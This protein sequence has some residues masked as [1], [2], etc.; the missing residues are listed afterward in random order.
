MALWHDV[1]YRLRALVGR[2]RLDHD[3]DEELQF[4]LEQETAARVAAGMSPQE[5]RRTAMRDFGGMERV[6]E[7]GREARGVAPLED[8][9]RDLRY[10][11]RSLSRAP[12]FSIVVI[13]TLALG[14]GA[15][16]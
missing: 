12:G 16:T 13:A 4:H 2:G 8:F 10:A 1:W 7:E 14:I 3:V 11:L 9:A 15:T 6:R 5:A